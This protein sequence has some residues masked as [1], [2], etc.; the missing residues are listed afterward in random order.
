MFRIIKTRSSHWKKRG[1]SAVDRKT[2][3]GRKSAQITVNIIGAASPGHTGG[4]QFGRAEPSTLCGSITTSQSPGKCFC[5]AHKDWRGM[6][7]RTFLQKLGGGVLHPDQGVSW[8]PG[9]EIHPGRHWRGAGI[10]RRERDKTRAVLLD[11]APRGWGGGLIP[12]PGR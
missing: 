1:K 4:S 11:G 5:P 7:P 9:H 10:C 6:L 12:G 2:G 8:D 3:N